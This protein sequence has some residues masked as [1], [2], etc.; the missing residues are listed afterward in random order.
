MID[1]AKK[2]AKARARVI[3]Q[4]KALLNKTV[5]NGCTEGEADAAAKLARDLMEKYKITGEELRGTDL[6]S[7]RKKK[8]QRPPR[9]MDMSD[10]WAYL[11]EDRKSTRLNS[12]H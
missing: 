9:T 7:E 2:K 8:K 11:P 4:I 6:E 3:K 10:F 1:D 5:A 12:S